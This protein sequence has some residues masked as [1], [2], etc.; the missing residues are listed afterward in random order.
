LYDATVTDLRLNDL[1]IDVAN[2]PNVGGIAGAAFGTK[3]VLL[4]CSVQGNIRVTEDR[5]ATFV[6]AGGLVGTGNLSNADNLRFDGQVYADGVSYVRIGGIIGHTAG[7]TTLK[8]CKSTGKL[9]GFGYSVYVGGI[10]GDASI[11]N[12]ADSVSA[13]DVNGSASE[14]ANVGGI[15]AY[16]IR[17]SVTHCENTGSVTGASPGLACGGIVAFG[18]SDVVLRSCKNSGAINAL[19]APENGS[20]LRSAANAGGVAGELQL[21]SSVRDCFNAGEVRCNGNFTTSYVGGVV[22]HLIQTEMLYCGNTGNVQITAAN[23]DAENICGGVVGFAGD[24]N[25]Q[26]YGCYSLAD[27][28]ATGGSVRVGGVVGSVYDVSGARH[29]F[30]AS[31]RNCYS[32]GNVA[33]TATRNP[34]IDFPQ[35]YALAGGVAGSVSTLLSAQ[36][37]S[38]GNC[39]HYGT[40]QAA[41]PEAHAGGVTGVSQGT[42]L[43]NCYAW[44][45]NGNG[46]VGD[47]TEFTLIV[48]SSTLSA[49]QMKQPSAFAGFDFT[50]VWDIAANQNGGMPRLR[51]MQLPD[52]V[53]P[54]MPIVY[55]ITLNSNGGWISASPPSVVS[56]VNG[57]VYGVLPA[58]TSPERDLN[59]DGWYT[60]LNG[61]TKINPTDVVNLTENITLYA[62][63]AETLPPV[64]KT[65]FSTKYE[66]T[67]WNW[68]LFIVCFGW[69]W[70]WF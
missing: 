31:V 7:N 44:N 51:A 42:T 34:E 68:F 54:G 11:A 38:L 32:Q 19:P 6:Y 24:D 20:M 52:N 1:Q 21:S 33:A 70:M 22:G 15:A 60:A 17:G 55:T 48:S 57:G 59:F 27:V 69:I 26:I 10:A 23:A 41:G 13:M 3:T 2:C 63:W 56:V 50:T 67:G 4:N 40:V 62:H 29:N 45:G 35:N 65:I 47:Q 43:Y 64:A 46:I 53:R 16:V 5:N 37:T 58:P 9:D 49:A 61:G 12:I 28:T 30:K 14:S 25:T 66:A 18:S 39:Y 36:G 8:N